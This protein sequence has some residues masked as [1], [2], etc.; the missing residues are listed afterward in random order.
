[1]YRDRVAS[2]FYY[3]DEEKRILVVNYTERICELGFGGGVV[4][5]QRV[6]EYFQSRTIDQARPDLKEYLARLG[7]TEYNSY[8]MVRETHG[9]MWDDYQWV[10]FPDD[11]VTYEEIKIRD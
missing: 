6:Y 8:K 2:D 11:T 4:T 1:M 9:L 3:C 10:R 7:L 5:P